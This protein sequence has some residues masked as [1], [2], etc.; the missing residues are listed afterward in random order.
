M[1][2]PDVGARL[3]LLVAFLRALAETF[4]DYRRYLLLLTANQA[5]AAID[6]SIAR[7]HTAAQLRA[8]RGASIL[9][10]AADD[11]PAAARSVALA[12]AVSWALCLAFEGADEESAYVLP[13]PDDPIWPELRKL[14][15]SPE[16]CQQ[17]RRVWEQVGKESAAAQAVAS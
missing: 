14:G 4:G 9:R 11:T 2:R 13:T 7:A 12:N 1:R 17:L 5:G 3:V 16:D 6:G 10:P 15:W 8:M